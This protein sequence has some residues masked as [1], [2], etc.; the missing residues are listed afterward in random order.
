MTPRIF[1]PTRALFGLALA[2]PLLAAC[3][4]DAPEQGELMLS[5]TTDMAVPNDI[6][7]VVWS[8]TLDGE[9]KPFA[10]ETVELAKGTDLPLTL[11][12]QAGPKTTAPIT[13]RVEGR[14]GAAPSILRVSREAKLVVPKDR[15]ATLQL[16]LSWLCSGA[17]LSEPCEA[18]TTCEA[19]HCVDT[20]LA[21]ASLPDFQPSQQ[22]E[23][24]DVTA[25]LPSAILT[26]VGPLTLKAG[27]EVPCGILGTKLL[28][29]DADVNVA[30]E[31]SHERVGNYGFCGPFGECF[32]PLHRADTPEGWHVLDNGDTPA[33]ELPRAVC[34][35]SQ[36][37]ITRVAI[38]RAS[39][40]CP[41]DR[42]DRPLCSPSRAKE[43]LVAPVCPVTS[44]E[45]AWA[46]YACTD[47]DPQDDHP[48]LIKCWSPPAL[49]SAGDPQND[50]RWCCLRGQPA[51]DDPLLIDDMQGGP[52]IKLEAPQGHFAGWWYA[53]IPD[54]SGDLSPPPEPSLYT[55]R[56]FD[57]PVGPPG[58][59]Q[60]HAAACLS[61][62]GFHGWFA[63]EGFYFGSTVG[64][65]G[66]DA[67]D[68]SEYAGISFWGWANEPFPDDPLAV[69]VSF[70]N[71]QA[72]DQPGS[73]CITAADGT[74]R[75][76]SYFEEVALTGEWK[77]YVV[78]WEDLAQTQED[79][80]QFRFHAFN[81]QV[82]AIN[83]AVAGAGPDFTSQ[84]FEFCVTD[85]RF[86]PKAEV[87]Q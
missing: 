20:L 78:R 85:V 40:R 26:S 28:G 2:L 81:P 24:Y 25:C 76:D 9:T 41:S 43:C 15:V 74:T 47:A 44:P 49:S 29:P 65:Y 31:V 46:G 22:L 67:R 71:V 5:I 54:G 8:V 80:G 42:G 62:K 87:S 82:Y 58:G 3:S 32:V 61:S 70:P 34:E 51:S 16:P 63:L 18:G 6:D 21:T 33:I 4:N 19:G 10:T 14:K 77:H 55:Y 48:D 1:V 17:N 37:S 27:R 72:S 84:P 75:C 56:Q 68:V 59:P 52:Q 13:V 66:S 35:D 38:S 39:P 60:F 73:E 12:I 50:G 11:A 7:R 86:E 79:W 57:E 30:L 45:S 69:S 83:F 23:C 53:E 64:I 36:T